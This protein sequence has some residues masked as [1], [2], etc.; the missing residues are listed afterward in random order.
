MP[1]VIPPFV[2]YQ[3]QVIPLRGLWN[4]APLEGDKFCN[5][6]ISWG[7]YPTTAIQFSLSGNSP[8]AISQ[9]VAFSVDNSRCGS[10]IDFL[11][12][13]S[14][15]VLTVPAH[16]QLVAPVFTNALMFYAVASNAGASDMT[17]FQVCNSMPPPVP[18]NPSEAMNHVSETGIPLH[19]TSNV[20]IP[21]LASPTSGL[22]T[23][24]SINWGESTDTVPSANLELIDGTSTVLWAGTINTTQ[25]QINITPI[26]V[27]FKLGI[28]LGILG[29]D[30]GTGT[31][32]VNLYYT[33]P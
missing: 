17:V 4:S 29:S 12:P 8:V 16:N 22:L 15:F 3:E 5:F 23:G 7:S 26:N 10:D 25:G 19:Q 18:I 13:D 6:S 21:V 30:Y 20:I 33:S 14:G 9:I 32:F 27:R 11:F 1:Q 24:F 2:Q 28:S 31:I